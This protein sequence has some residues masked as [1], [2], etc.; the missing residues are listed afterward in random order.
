MVTSIEKLVRHLEGNSDHIFASA[1]YVAHDV[2]L[3]SILG[4]IFVV[5][6]SLNA[7]SLNLFPPAVFLGRASPKTEGLLWNQTGQK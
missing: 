1:F 3:A 7:V 4:L 5:C 6:P 2:R